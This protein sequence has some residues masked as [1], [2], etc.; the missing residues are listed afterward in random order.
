M[1]GLDLINDKMG[2]L[3]HMGLDLLCPA[4]CPFCGEAAGQRSELC[5][6]C[7][8]IYL[9][10]RKRRCP[11]CGQTV[12]RCACGCEFQR[13]SRTVIDG[14]TH[15]S[16]S[17][18]MGSQTARSNGYFTE[19]MIL[20]L[21]DHGRFARFFA[22]RLSNEV[23]HLFDSAAMPLNDW[24]LTYTPRS[25]ANFTKAGL[26]QSEE[27][28]R[29]MSRRLK[30]PC[31]KTFAKV[32]GDEQKTLSAEDRMVNACTTLVPRKKAIRH[33]GKYLLFDDIIT[34]G[35]TVIAASRHLYFCGAAEVFPI[36]L[37]RSIP[38]E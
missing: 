18:Y 35:A 6:K 14:R 29:Y 36:S 4:V 26:D 21:K 12:D 38:K 27:V 20:Q 32:E 11:Q 1:S 31:V 16:L 7:T 24:I 9:S 19:Q 5:A 17:F 23:E 28:T 22:D 10:E 33:G 25:I 30:I 15:L 34:S 13:F 3:L 2:R 37:A 8:S